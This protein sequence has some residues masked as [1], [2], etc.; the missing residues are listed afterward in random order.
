MDSVLGA[1]NHPSS[2]SKPVREP[3]D[4][5]PS[6]ALR[7]SISDLRPS[8]RFGLVSATYGPRW[9]FGLVSPCAACGITILPRG[10]RLDLWGSA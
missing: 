6:L 3:S 8:L 1:W 9:R 5:Q 10:Y 4:L 2:C 7:V